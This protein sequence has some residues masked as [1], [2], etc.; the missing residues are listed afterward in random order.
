MVIASLANSAAVFFASDRGSSETF[1]VV[2]TN[3]IDGHQ[4]GQDFVVTI[5]AAGAFQ[6]N[7]MAE[8]IHVIAPMAEIVS[9]APILG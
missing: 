3:G 7:A 9:V 5:V 2:D 8:Q 1:L 6:E 4:A